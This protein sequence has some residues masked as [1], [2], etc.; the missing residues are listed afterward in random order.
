MIPYRDVYKYPRLKDH[1]KN[2]YMIEFIK[3][4]IDDFYN[5]MHIGKVDHWNSY[6]DNGWIIKYHCK[7]CHKLEEFIESLFI[8]G[9]FQNFD[10]NDNHYFYRYLNIVLNELHDDHKDVLDHLLQS[11]DE[12]LRG[13]TSAFV[14]YRKQ[15]DEIEEMLI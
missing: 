6:Y 5:N 3:T 12:T 15:M 9:H 7:P 11:S 13:N 10:I 14:R 4:A 8:G 1:L 2:R